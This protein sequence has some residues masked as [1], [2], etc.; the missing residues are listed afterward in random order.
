M[1]KF[2]AVSEKSTKIPRGCFLLLTRYIF[3]APRYVYR[4][5]N[6]LMLRYVNKRS[7]GC[8][9]LSA[10]RARVTL[11]IDIESWTDWK[12]CYENHAC[13]RP[14]AMKTS[15]ALQHG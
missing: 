9:S 14:R 15:I 4:Y 6:L 10:F 11:L 1:L 2:P 7:S 3:T 12:T 8:R 5:K 13:T